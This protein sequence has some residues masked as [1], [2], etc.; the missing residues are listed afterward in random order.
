M[1]PPRPHVAIDYTPALEQGG[2]IGRYVRELVSA[3]AAVD[4]RNPYVLFAAGQRTE[5]LPA[6][7]A[8]NFAWRSSR[9]NPNWFARI[10][11]RA[12]LPL[13]V[14]WWTGDVALYHA[15][16]FTLPP[17]RRGT[18]TLLTVH[19][20][21]YARTPE[22]AVASLR[23]Y[24][25]RVV[26]Q[27]A[28]RAD[29]ILADSEAT[30]Q[31]LIALYAVPP[32]K[33]SVLYCGVEPRFHPITDAD[34]LRRVRARYAI[35]DNPYILSVGTVQPRKNYARLAEAFAR[36]EYTG[37]K[38]VIA[39][40]KGW[41]EDELYRVIEHSGIANRVLLTGFVADDDLPALYSGAELMAYPALYEGFGLPP[42]EAMACGVPVITSN[43]SSFPEVVGDAGLMIDPYSVNDLAA[44]IERVLTSPSLRTTLCQMGL[45]RARLFDWQASARQL[46]AHYDMLLATG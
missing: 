17:V 29:H 26:P 23:R 39:G 37:L 31:D 1:Q 12:H 14:E 20:L 27:S 34:I 28:A 2:G 11:H 22:T 4:P 21:S 41:L 15:T 33:I 32:E 46:M 43:T 35:G 45:A 19:D 16:D 18:R 3:L 36:L 6:L 44:A 9:I 42:L 10:W 24:L 30:R 5:A 13:P 40:G 8:P 38:L 25:D 7:P